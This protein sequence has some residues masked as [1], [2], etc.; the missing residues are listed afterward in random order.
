MITLSAIKRTL[1]F[2]DSGLVITLSKPVM[3]IIEVGTQGPPGPGAAFYTHN[4]PV[5]SATWVI[6]HNLGY[7]PQISLFTVGGAEFEGEIVNITVNQ[8]IVYLAVATA[9]SARCA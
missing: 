1:T 4:Q 9:G 6:N 7:Y 5:A 3:S 2:L 8:A